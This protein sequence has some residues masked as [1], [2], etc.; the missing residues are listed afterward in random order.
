MRAGYVREMSVGEVLRN[1]VLIYRENFLPTF[2][3][4]LLP[5]LPGT[6]LIALG[7]LHKSFALLVPGYVLLFGGGL[8][9]YIAVTFVVS[10]ACVGNLPDVKRSFARTFGSLGDLMGVSLLQILLIAAGLFALLIPGI[11]F[12]IWFA[13]API[14]VIL[15]GRGGIEALKRS[16]ALTK[17]FFW[18]NLA[19]A[20]FVGIMLFGSYLVVFALGG[21]GGYAMAALGISA[22]VVQAVGSTLGLL[23]VALTYPLLFVSIVLAYYDLRARKE[24]YDVLVLASELGR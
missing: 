17:G 13:F 9:S 14:I 15:E 23:G 6:I 12:T 19:I 20:L 3:V 5:N 10:D 24:Q 1:S 22:E 11:L 2:L 21:I 16:K 4:Y 7:L 8:I 18:R